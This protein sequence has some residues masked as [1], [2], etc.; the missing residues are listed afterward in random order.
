MNLR[1]TLIECC[2][3]AIEL[4]NFLKYSFKPTRLSQ[5]THYEA[6]LTK[7]YHVVEKGMALPD[8]KAGFGKHKI[9]ELIRRLEQYISLYGENE[10]TDNIVSVLNEY[11]KFNNKM[12]ADGSAVEAVEGFLARLSAR[13]GQVMDTGGLKPLGTRHIDSSMLLQAMRSRSSVRRFSEQA[14]PRELILEAVDSAKHAPSVCNRQGW[15]LHI[16]EQDDKRDML[17]LQFGNAGFSDSIKTLGVITGDLRY[18]SHN[19]R[20]QV[21][22]DSGMFAMSLML[23]LQ[24]LGLSTCPLNTCVSFRGENKIKRKGDIPTYEKVIM[25]LAIGYAADDCQVTKSMRR[26]S[27]SFVTFH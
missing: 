6:Y 23:A 14:V 5:K 16:Y 24:G 13:Q 1:E 7:Q 18:F 4:K 25:Y 10:L 12:S 15:K 2:N 19:E 17:K 11:A 22:I 3:S 9:D 20:S 27:D 8:P 21:G 26:G